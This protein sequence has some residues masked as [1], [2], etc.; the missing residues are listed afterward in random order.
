M[1]DAK[2]LACDTP[3]GAQTFAV[4]GLPI[5]DG[6]RTACDWATGPGAAAP[7]LLGP[8][9]EPYLLRRDYVTNSNDSYWLAN[10][11]HPLNGFARIIGTEGTE[12]S[13]RRGLG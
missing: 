10:P 4:L 11:H 6:S 1:P 3:L 5:L 7:G 12:R 8:G 2:A 13:L 9:Q